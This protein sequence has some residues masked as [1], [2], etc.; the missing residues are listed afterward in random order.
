M[1]RYPSITGRTPEE[2]I[3]QIKKELFLLVDQMNF[4]LT[5]LRKEVNDHVDDRRGKTGSV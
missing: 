5:K 2:K 3:E 1:L 4:E